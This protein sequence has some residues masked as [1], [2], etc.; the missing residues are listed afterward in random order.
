MKK[1]I[2]YLLASNYLIIF[3]LPIKLNYL[4]FSF[5]IYKKKFN[6]TS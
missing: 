1:M 4:L 3:Q 2:K 5:N 6:L